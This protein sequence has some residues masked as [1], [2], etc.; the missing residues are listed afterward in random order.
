MTG[1]ERYWLR[2]IRVSAR[3]CFVPDRF[4][5]CA[6]LVCEFGAITNGHIHYRPL[7]RLERRDYVRRGTAQF[8]FMLGVWTA[9]VRKLA[10]D[11]IDN[12]P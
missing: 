8:T 6:A 10:G 2:R 12:L 4:K 11:V 3:N 5:P 1:C 7:T 9:S